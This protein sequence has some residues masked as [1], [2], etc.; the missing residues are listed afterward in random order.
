MRRFKPRAEERTPETEEIY[1]RLLLSGV[2]VQFHVAE[3]ESV[4]F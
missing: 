2:Q 4:K 1:V 3:K